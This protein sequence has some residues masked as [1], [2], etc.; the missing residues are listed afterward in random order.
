MGPQ[1]SSN[2]KTK[3]KMQSIERNTGFI[4]FDILFER[5]TVQEIILGRGRELSVVIK[6][7]LGQRE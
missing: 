2:V 7:I 3:T 1:G 6:G 5:Q 4:F